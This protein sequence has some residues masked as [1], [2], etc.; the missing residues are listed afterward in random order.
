MY[1]IKD[2][3]KQWKQFVHNRVTDIRRLVAEQHWLHCAGTDNPAD[4]PSRGISSKHLE[5]NLMWRHG[6]D[7]LC[8]FSPAEHSEEEPMPEDCTSEMKN[9]S[10]HTLLVATENSTIGQLI[11]CAHYSKLHKLLRVTALVQNLQQDSVCLYHVIRRQ[12]TGQLPL[13]ILKEQK[14]TGLLIVRSN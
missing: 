8:K 2:Q 6:P 10:S 5:M 7:W 1:W 14:W 9:T 12:L 4:L 13:W 11:N 3:G